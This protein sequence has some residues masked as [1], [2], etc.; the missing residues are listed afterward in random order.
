MKTFR[1]SALYGVLWGF[2][3]TMLFI[4]L[5]MTVTGCSTLQPTAALG[6]APAAAPAAPQYPSW[7]QMKEGYAEECAAAPGG[8]VP[9]TQEELRQIIQTVHQRTLEQC[10]RRI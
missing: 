4:V 2:T 5:M 10:N 9:M 8:C 1:Q 7:L 3:M 6:A